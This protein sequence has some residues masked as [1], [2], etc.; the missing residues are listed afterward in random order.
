MNY[1][2]MLVL[3]SVGYGTLVFSQG[4]TLEE[5]LSQAVVKGDAPLVHYLLGKLDQEG[6][7]ATRRA[8]VG[9]VLSLSE[10]ILLQEKKCAGLAAH[11]MQLA[12]GCACLLIGGYVSCWYEEN[13]GLLE[14]YRRWKYRI[15]QEM[16]D[17]YYGVGGLVGALFGAGYIYDA[18]R[19]L[20]KPS[21]IRDA[22]SVRNSLSCRYEELSS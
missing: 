20:R 6:T 13:T 16:V 10:K 5:R 17:Y 12:A 3:C 19:S 14:M 18:M 4:S 2:M 8:V 7:H 15:D 9:G 22:Q 11:G 21:Q 1:R